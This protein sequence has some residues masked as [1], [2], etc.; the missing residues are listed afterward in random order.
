MASLPPISATTRLIQIW[1]FCGFAASSLMCRPTSREPVKEMKRVFGMRHEKVADRPP[2]PVRKQNDSRRKA[3]F[4][5]RFGKHRPR[6]WASRS[7][8]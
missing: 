3:G 4:E 8:A 2:L 6:R 7:K 5:Q 1:P